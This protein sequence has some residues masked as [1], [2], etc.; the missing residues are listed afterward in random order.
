MVDRGGTERLGL[1]RPSGL[2][3][4]KCGSGLAREYGGTVNIIAS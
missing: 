2:A 3:Q 4:I 1:V